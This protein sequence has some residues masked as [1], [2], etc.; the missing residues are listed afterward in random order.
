MPAFPGLEPGSHRIISE[1]RICGADLPVSTGS[2]LPLARMFVPGRRK[3]VGGRRFA[4]ENLSV[5]LSESLVSIPVSSGEPDRATQ[6]RSISNVRFLNIRL[7]KQVRAQGTS[8]IDLSCAAPFAD[9]AMVS[10]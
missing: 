3:G 4:R 5:R 7:C 6:F 2:P 10:G 9:R 8:A 1:G